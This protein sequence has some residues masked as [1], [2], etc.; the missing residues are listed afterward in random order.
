MAQASGLVSLE[1]E[2]AERTW[3]D[4]G[5]EINYILNM[6]PCFVSCRHIRR[7]SSGKALGPRLRHPPA[8][9]PRIGAFRFTT[10]TMELPS[11]RELELETAL[12]QRNAQVA[13]LSVTAFRLLPAIP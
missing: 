11:A 13:D 9:M 2:T 8:R 4:S 1:N 10:T 6:G 5:N 12:R 3:E 7:L